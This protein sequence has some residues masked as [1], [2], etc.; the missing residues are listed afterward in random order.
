MMQVNETTLSARQIKLR[1]GVAGPDK[2]IGK[3]GTRR[4]LNEGEAGLPPT[5]VKDR[6]Q[7]QTRVRGMTRGNLPYTAALIS[8]TKDLSGSRRCRS[9]DDKTGKPPPLPLLDNVPA[10]AALS[11]S[12]SRDE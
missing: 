7:A 6:K 12:L 11:L 8:V 5:L 1:K 9:S 10:I 2:L 3:L 4:P